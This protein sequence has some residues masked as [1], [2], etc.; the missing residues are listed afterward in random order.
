MARTSNKSQLI[1]D[2]V[3]SFIQENGCAPGASA[4]GAF[5]CS[6]YH[7]KFQFIAPFIVQHCRGRR[8]RRPEK[9]LQN[10]DKRDVQGAVPYKLR[11][12]HL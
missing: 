7:R 9:T 2:F 5:A 4:P 11:F 6:S 8:L 10:L 3:G 1:L 12:N